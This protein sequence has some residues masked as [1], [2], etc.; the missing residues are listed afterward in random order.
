MWA[1]SDVSSA[2]SS[3]GSND[4]TRQRPSRRGARGRL[5]AAAGTPAHRHHQPAGQRASGG[6]VR[7]RLSRRS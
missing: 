1:R 4:P 6:R 5:C 3:D 7:R 2:P